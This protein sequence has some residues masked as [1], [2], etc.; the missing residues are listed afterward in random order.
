MNEAVKRLEHYA[1]SKDGYILLE[2]RSGNIFLYK[3]KHEGHTNV[4]RI[5]YSVDDLNKYN[6]IINEIWDSNHVNSF[7]TDF[8]KITRVYNQN[9]VMIQKRC[10]KV[11]FGRQRYFYALVK[12]FQVRKPFLFCFVINRISHIMTP[13]LFKCTFI[14]FVYIKRHNYNCH[15][16]R[17]INDHNPS[18]KEFKNSIIENVNLFKADINS[19]EDTRNGKL[20]KAFV[21]IDGYLIK[22]KHDSYIDI[23]FVSSINGH[24]YI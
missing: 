18:S 3:K 7:N 15:G 8:V 11:F 4:E 24:A 13:N 22:K 1:I 6:E 20:K 9:L 17:N 16:F 12:K 23:T 19:E 14:N 2:K 5:I 21:N 10:K